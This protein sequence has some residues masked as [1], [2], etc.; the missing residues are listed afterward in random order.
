MAGPKVFALPLAPVLTR[1]AILVWWGPDL[2]MLY[3]DAHRDI[4]S[5]KHPAAL[6]TQTEGAA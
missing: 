5:S 6:G 1:F 4:I 2:I 3:N